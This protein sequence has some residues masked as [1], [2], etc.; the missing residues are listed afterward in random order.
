[1]GQFIELIGSTIIAGFIILIIIN[2]NIRMNSTAA[3]FVQSSLNQ[4]NAIA[5]GQILEYDFYKIG[6][7]AGTNK[8]FQ[9][10][11]GRISFAASLNNDASI[12]TI[13][14]YLSSTSNLANTQNPNDRLLYRR[15]NQ[16]L[17]YAGIVTRFYIQYYDSLLNNLTY[18]SLTTQANRNRI[19]VVK[20]YIRNELANQKD[21]TYSPVEWQK[22]FRPRNLR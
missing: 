9:A 18:A 10:D 4:R 19:K 15:V 7:K 13:T 5:I 22:E 3:S 20:A 16:Q 12:D 2:L 6:F 11:S 17:S 14:Y 8:I 1:M 21:G